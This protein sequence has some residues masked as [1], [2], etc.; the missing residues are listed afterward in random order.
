MDSTVVAQSPVS[1]FAASWEATGTPPNLADYLPEREDQR[2]DS[3]IELIR[4]DLRYRWLEFDKPKRLAAYREE[5]PE[6]K[7]EPL[8]PELIHEEFRLRRESGLTVEASDYSRDFPEESQVIKTPSARDDQ[9]TLIATPVAETALEDIDVGQQVDDFDL[10]MGLGRGAFARVFLARQRSMER[11]VAVKVSHDHGTEPQTLAQLDHDYIVR[12]FDQRVLGDHKLKLLYMQY[13][14]G[15]TLLG[16]LRRVQATAPEDRSGQLLLDVI[17]EALESKGEIRPSDSSVRAEIA[18]LTWPETVAWL[19]R[20]LAEALDYA[21]KHGV[22]HR[23]IKPA[24]V[25]LTAE[26]V[27]KLADFNISFSD[28]VAGASPVAYFG[29]SLAYMSPEQLAACH[30]GL[31]GTASD[32]DTRSDIFGLGVMLWELLTGAR[33]FDDGPR[34]GQSE[35]S[36]ERMLAVRARGVDEES[37]AELP[38]DC[39]AALKRVLLTCLA[40]EPRGRWSTGAELAQQFELCLDPRARDLVDPGPKSWRMLLRRLVIPITV[41]AMLIPN[42]LAGVYNYH[43]NK[44]L[45]VSNLS[46]EAQQK[47]E[48]LQTVMNGILY[49]IGIVVVVY[50]SR[51]PM[52]MPRGLR[53][54]R[55]YDKQTLAKA[56]TDTLM[57]ADRAVLVMFGMWSV[58][59][60]AYPISL[61]AVAGEIPT[62]ADIHFFVSLVVC[63]AI[64]V[65]YPFFLVAF[66]LVRCIYPMMLPQGITSSDDARKLRGLSRRSVRYLALAASVPLVGVAGVTFLSPDEITS[67]IVAVRVLCVGAIAAFILVYW[68]FR[69]LEKDLRALERVVSHEPATRSAG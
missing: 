43:H 61:R 27:P 9:N 37:Q 2:R 17:D 57:L 21:G 8:P 65:S 59:G 44:S 69:M 19:G 15:G 30:P 32:L 5:F 45:I 4:V 28:H 36:L 10:L 29:G 58:A 54:G 22:L 18:P 11:L 16:V 62:S 53:K 48:Q 49:P 41:L 39:P 50:L 56:R 52:R 55:I 26:G 7:S 20:R 23:D 66:Y 13:V 33:P 12:V 46:V 64:A 68:L 1:R 35:G 63:G 31:P 67:V 25:L 6:L 42:V 24:N 38:P 3:L 34:G 60:I 14:P 51:Y 47:F 40:P